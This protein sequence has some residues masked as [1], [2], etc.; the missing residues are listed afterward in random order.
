MLFRLI[1]PLR[2]SLERRTAAIHNDEEAGTKIEFQFRGELHHV[3]QRGNVRECSISNEIG[4]LCGVVETEAFPAFGG[5]R[6]VSLVGCSF[7]SQTILGTDGIGLSLTR[8]ARKNNDELLVCEREF[9]WCSCPPHV[10]E[11]S[12]T[13]LGC[14]V[15]LSSSHLSGSTIRDV[16]TGGSVLC[17]NSSFSSFLSSPNTD[18]NADSDASPSITLPNGTHREFV[19]DGTE[20]SFNNTSGDESSIASFSHCHFTGANYASNVHPPRS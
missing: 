11:L 2:E 19:D 4:H 7:N 1:L 8:T 3:Q 10:S 18:S 14:V 17:S 16:N 6:S 20:Y 15:S 13:M 5:S 9:D 12:Q